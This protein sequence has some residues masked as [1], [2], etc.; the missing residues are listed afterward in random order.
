MGVA[1]AR[2]FRITGDDEYRN[3]AVRTADAIRARLTDGKGV[4]LDDRDAWANGAFA[5]SGRARCSR[6][7]GSPRSISTSCGPRLGDSRASAHPGWVLRRLVERA[8]GRTGLTLEQHRQP[9]AADHDERQ[10][11]EHDRRG[12]HARG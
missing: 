12:G 3:K 5:G 8:G 4:L 2:L 11:G 1:Q 6:Y 7:R 10:C 9:P